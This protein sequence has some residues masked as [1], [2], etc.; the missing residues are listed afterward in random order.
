MAE[1]TEARA[2][3]T[4]V[5]V[6]DGSSPP[7][8]PASDASGG[9]GGGG[10]SFANEGNSGSKRPELVTQRS[11]RPNVPR[12]YSVSRKV[13]KDGTTKTRI[14]RIWQKL[15]VGGTVFDGFLLA[16]SQE[17]GQSILALPM[18]F[19]QLGFAGGIIFEI[20]FATTALYTCVLLVQMHG[21]LSKA[22]KGGSPKPYDVEMWCI[23]NMIFFVCHSHST[24]SLF[25]FNISLPQR[26]S[27]MT[28]RLRRIRGIS[29]NTTSLRI[30]KSWST[31]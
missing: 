10:G 5:K 11:T 29:M 25:N 15:T 18:V 30:M 16:A 14:K 28:S 6:A 21:K 13:V 7:E 19:A 23:Y 31:M 27:V 9:S 24:F 20:F 12:G 3:T 22:C 17:V 2:S 26:N 8:G 1:D 4:S